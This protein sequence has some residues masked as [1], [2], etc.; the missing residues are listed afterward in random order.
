MFK[1]EMNKALATPLEASLKFTK[2]MFLQI[3]SEKKNMKKVPYQS[4]VGSLM[5]CM[6]CI[7]LTLHIQW[8]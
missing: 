1:L 2:E 3:E 7:D 5:Y 6:I 4:V 8:E